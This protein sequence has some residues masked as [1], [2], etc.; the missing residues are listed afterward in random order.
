LALLSFSVKGNILY[1][2]LNTRQHPWPDTIRGR[3]T[4]NNQSLTH[5]YSHNGWAGHI[6]R[7]AKIKCGYKE[8]NK[9]NKINQ[10]AFPTFSCVQQLVRYKNLNDT[11]YLSNA[12]NPVG[13]IVHSPTSLCKPSLRKRKALRTRIHLNQLPDYPV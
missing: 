5:T 10:S 2:E 1:S 9:R 3:E 7:Y 11:Y 13:V 4:V 8:K 12:I 6:W